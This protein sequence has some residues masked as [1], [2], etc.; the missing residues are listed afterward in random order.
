MRRRR[1]ATSPLPTRRSGRWRGSRRSDMATTSIS[2]INDMHP[3]MVMH[4]IEAAD[5]SAT[6]S[7][8]CKDPNGKALFVDFVNVV[9]KDGAGFVAYDWPKPGFDKPQPKLSYVVGFAPLELG[10]RHRRLY[11]RPRCADL[12]L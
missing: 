4:P 12:G 6:I 3:R 10:H 2:G 9:K 11:R 1:K 7:R 8:T 5:E